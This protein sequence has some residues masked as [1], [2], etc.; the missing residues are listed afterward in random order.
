MS[1]APRLHRVV[2]WRLGT[3]APAPETTFQDFFSTGIFIR[4]E[5]GEHY[6][7]SGVAGRIWT[8]SGRYE[9]F[10]AAADYKEYARAGTAKV[11]LLT[12]VHG[13]PKG[14]E[15]R[16]EARVFC[17]GRRT[18]LAFWPFWQMVHPFGRLIGA[19][20]LAAAVARAGGPGSSSRP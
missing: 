15:I 7:V 20:G 17:S 4:L 10:A 9:Q 16:I 2:R 3:H 18:R 19:E 11:A 14:S 5:E 12:E 6:S 13:H 8:P 1:D